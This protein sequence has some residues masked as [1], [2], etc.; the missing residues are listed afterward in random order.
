MGTHNIGQRFSTGYCQKMFPFERFE[1]L[2]YFSVID[3]T[4]EKVK[5]NVFSFMQLFT[6]Y[7]LV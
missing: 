3:L 2:N 5:H 6:R 1:I 7:S 4:A